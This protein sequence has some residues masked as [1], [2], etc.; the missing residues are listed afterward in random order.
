MYRKLLKQVCTKLQFNEG[1]KFELFNTDVKPFRADTQLRGG[2]MH[3]L[4]V[5]FS[6]LSNDKSSHQ[7]CYQRKSKD[8]MF[9]MRHYS[10]RLQFVDGSEAQM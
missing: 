5:I 8:F 7:G 9:I 4:L 1:L 2:V 6:F 3:Q 10:Q